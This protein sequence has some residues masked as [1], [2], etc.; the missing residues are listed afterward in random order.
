MAEDTEAERTDV[1]VDD[2]PSSGE[3]PIDT[4]TKK[5]WQVRTWLHSKE[6]DAPSLEEMLNDLDANGYE[7]FEM[8][9]KRNLVVGKLRESLHDEHPLG[10]GRFVGPV[11]ISE[12]LRD[13]MNRRRP[14]EEAVAAEP[15]QTP[16][17]APPTPDFHITGSLTHILFGRLNS[18]LTMGQMGDTQTE[19]RVKETI[20]D[21]FKINVPRVEVEKSLTDVQNYYEWHVKHRGAPCA[22][23]CLLEKVFTISKE[24]LQ[25]HL[26]TNQAN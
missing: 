15:A 5:T 4:R 18:I 25:A 2:E 1:P 3:V 20:A 8:S 9:F 26:T 6:S 13:I 22:E 10:V 12:V 16:G 17:E 14:V 11:P 21:L 24:R 23:D 7:V 19:K